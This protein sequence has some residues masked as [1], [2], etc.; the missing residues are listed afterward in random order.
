MNV[1]NLV[2]WCEEDLITDEVD[3]LTSQRKF[4]TVIRPRRVHELQRVRDE[5]CCFTSKIEKMKQVVLH[6]YLEGKR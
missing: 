3:K 1:S 4:I 2:T 5:V 6:V